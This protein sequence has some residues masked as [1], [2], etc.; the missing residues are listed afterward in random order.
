MTTL[1]MHPVSCTKI[2]VSVHTFPSGEYIIV[3]PLWGAC[4]QLSSLTV[5]EAQ[6]FFCSRPPAH[7]L[8]FI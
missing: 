8:G 4:V 6:A 5:G 1:P 3:I 7:P 2:R